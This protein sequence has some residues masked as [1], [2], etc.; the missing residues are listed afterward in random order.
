[1]FNK[2]VFGKGEVAL[3]DRRKEVFPALVTAENP[4]HSEAFRRYHQA[5]LQEYFYSLR[6]IFHT[7]AF[8]IREFAI[9]FHGITVEKYISSLVWLTYVQTII[10]EMD[11]HVEHEGAGAA[12]RSAMNLA[13]VGDG[14]L[15]FLR[16]HDLLDEQIER[17]VNDVVLYLRRE[18]NQLHDKVEYTEEEIFATLD[19]KAADLEMLRRILLRV[20]DIEPRETELRVFKIID[21]VREAFDD[22][23]DY[24]EDLELANFNTVVYLQKRGGDMKRGAE[25]LSRFIDNELKEVQN[26]IAGLD[27]GP[28]GKLGAIYE[29]LET[30]CSYFMRQLAELPS[31]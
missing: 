3:I 23:R 2:E 17:C 7:W 14:I 28:R 25:I 11:I 19:L 5:Y 6:K 27:P 1:M 16:E 15:S 24:H 29:R 20:C 21:R 18:R 8:D 4:T 30:E 31:G 26:L 22:I 10:Y 12:R 13:R 9:D